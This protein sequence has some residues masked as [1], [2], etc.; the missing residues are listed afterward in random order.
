MDPSWHQFSL[1]VAFRTGHLKA[2]APPTHAHSSQHR[3]QNLQLSLPPLRPLAALS[4]LME[5][6]QVG[7]PPQTWS[8]LKPRWL[9]SLLHPE[10]WGTPRQH[11]G[12]VDG[13]A[14]PSS[15]HFR[16]NFPPCPKRHLCGSH[17]C[18]IT[19]SPWPLAAQEGRVD[20]ALGTQAP[21]QQQGRPRCGNP[22]RLKG[23]QGDSPCM[24]AFSQTSRQES[25]NPVFVQ[26]F[27]L[28]HAHL[29]HP[30]TC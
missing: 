6:Q 2:P 11:P 17:S 16:E 7:R 20:P 5:G 10:C 27:P 9:L 25:W 23:I 30:P 12:H 1:N 19:P 26:A 14:S 4:P 3:L 13:G 28:V 24:H 22:D 21:V 29:S 15:P 18:S 8:S